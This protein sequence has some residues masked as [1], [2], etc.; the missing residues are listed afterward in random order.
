M[1]S[2]VRLSVGF[3]LLTLWLG[4]ATKPKDGGVSGTIEQNAS[5][6][7]SSP[8]PIASKEKIK[9]GKPNQGSNAVHSG[10]VENKKDAADASAAG[11]AQLVET[12]A[13]GSMPISISGIPTSP[14]HDQKDVEPRT[15]GSSNADK[16][17]DQVSDKQVSDPSSGKTVDELP[18][19]DE[20][21]LEPPGSEVE[22]E[23]VSIVG[24]GI[25]E[26]PSVA[27]LPSPEQIKNDPESS[28]VTLE[29]R[30]NPDVVNSLPG[31]DPD[32]QGSDPGID[33]F[34]ETT[35]PHDVV[36]NTDSVA[37]EIKPSGVTSRG[38]ESDNPV[39]SPSRVREDGEASIVFGKPEL[40]PSGVS[41][42]K[43]HLRS[44]VGLGFADPLVSQ[45]NSAKSLSLGFSSR[46]IEPAL[47]ISGQSN[48]MHLSLRPDS[49]RSPGLGLLA[50]KGVGF[51]VPGAPDGLSKVNRRDLSVGFADSSSRRT[52]SSVEQGIN[53]GF[54]D[55]RGKAYIPRRP[56]VRANQIQLA[57][58]RSAN[59][60]D[61][62]FLAELFDFEGAD[63]NAVPRIKS[64]SPGFSVIQELFSS[65]DTSDA[66]SS[67]ALD[68][69]QAREGYRY[70]PVIEWL[71]LSGLIENAGE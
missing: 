69:V 31:G 37:E 23:P 10:G 60:R 63:E 57:K 17:E 19:K 50:G 61:Y 3:S 48:E 56:S 71:R 8:V 66:S 43:A 15:V 36:A 22:D 2:L 6:S 30:G 18:V 68:A 44:E 64:S 39:D 45:E 14:D 24:S 70:E 5:V 49:G 51:S 58:T 67:P 7:T 47:P 46:G 9:G 26:K 38:S 40:I 59:G 1:N 4:C 27:K 21:T 55:K 20:E 41:V 13:N 52:D 11:E 25:G 35:S 29:E 12:K 42:A 28:P 32:H 16:Q 34:F 65:V 62:A 33:S 54:S 53:V